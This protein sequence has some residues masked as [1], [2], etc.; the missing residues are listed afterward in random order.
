MSHE[1]ALAGDTVDFAAIGGGPAGLFGAIAYAEAARSADASADASARPRI[2][3]LERMPSPGRKLLASGSGQCNISHAGSVEELLLRYA[4]SGKAGEAARF[5]KLSLY[6]FDN[7][8]LQAW[9]GARGLSFRAEPNGKIFPTTRKSRS[10][11]DILVA[12]LGSLGVELI[13]SARCLS[14]VLEEDGFRLEFEGDRLVRARSVLLAAG[15][16]SYPL[17]GSSGDGFGL[18]TDLGHRVVTPRPALAPVYADDPTLTSLS[19]LTFERAG[20]ALW[21][22]GRKLWDCIGELLLTHKG[23]SGPLIL[24]T[25]RDIQPGDELRLRFTEAGPEA[26]EA[27]ID[28]L[29]RSSPKRLAKALLSEL[30]LPRSMA[31]R[32]AALAGLAD[33][34]ASALSRDSRRRLAGLAAAYPLRVVALGG[35]DAA[36]AT[37]G[38]VALSEV[39]PKTMESRSLP[40][41]YFAGEVLDYVGDTGGYN[42]QAAFSTGRLAGLSAA[43]AARRR[44]A[45]ALR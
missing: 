24:D 2:L 16:A 12:E 13:C 26:C 34:P 11:L 39:F 17:T 36:M 40:G 28:E 20:L 35:W 38:G 30:G 25:S 31:E 15:G 23:V 43:E 8:A 9:F 42:I 7:D 5:L 44:A 6:G 32:F 37:A 14:I 1:A 18:A 3:V 21:R 22:N 45:S 19:G 33:A 4:S 10:V 27:R 29:V 41:L